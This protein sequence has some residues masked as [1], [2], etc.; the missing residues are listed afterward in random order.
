MKLSPHFT[1]A[2]LT[3]TQQP[4]DNEPGEM[5]LASLVELCVHVLEPVRIVLGNKPITITSGYRSLPVNAA[6][7]GQ[8]NSQ[9]MLG[10]AADFVCPAF[11][12]PREV[13]LAIMASTDPRVPYDQLIFE[14]FGHG[15]THISWSPKPR[16]MAFRLPGGGSI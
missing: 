12:N 1:L 2:E 8:V 7:G 4:F 11:G 16:Q 6:V 14:N 3:A 13:C 15:W 5:A 10:Q 9:H